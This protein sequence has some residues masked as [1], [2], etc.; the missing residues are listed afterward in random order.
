VKVTG[1]MEKGSNTIEVENIAPA[2][3]IGQPAS[4][5][6]R[7]SMRTLIFVV[8]ISIAAAFAQSTQTDPSTRTIRE[9]GQ[10][11]QATQDTT[12][13]QAANTAS[14][15]GKQKAKPHRPQGKSKTATPGNKRD[16]E[17]SK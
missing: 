15:T 3:W 13:D 7:T 2:I 6:I 5:R 8:A 11:N 17:R 10:R 12:A 16:S 9:K 1:K 4:V 14:D